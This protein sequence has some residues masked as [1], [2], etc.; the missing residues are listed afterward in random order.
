MSNQAT[1][2]RD[3]SGA[4]LNQNHEELVRYREEI[5]KAKRLN[6]IEKQ[7]TQLN[8]RISELEKKLDAKNS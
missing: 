2:A 8:R 4:I 7:L 3:S 5:R 6:E 1:F